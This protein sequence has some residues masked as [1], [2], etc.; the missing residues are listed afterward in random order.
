[1]LAVGTLAACGGAGSNDSVAVVG[2]ARIAKATLDQWAAVLR[3]GRAAP[4]LS[5]AQREQLNERAL[6]Y[7]ISAEW[8]I[9]EAEDRSALPSAVEVHQRLDE[10]DQSSFPG[11]EA[12]LREFLRISGQTVA[13]MELEVR[14]QLIASRLRQLAIAAAPAVTKAQ[15]AAYYNAHP[16]AFIVAEER[17]I[18]LADRKSAAAAEAMMRRVRAGASLAALGVTVTYERPSS[19]TAGGFPAELVRAIY[20]AAPHVLT[21]PVK[22]G[23]DY[24]V[25]EV[26]R[27][28]PPR[29]ETLQQASPAIAQQLHEASLRRALTAAVGAW[30]ARWTAQTNC[31]PGYVVQK[32]R[33][34]SGPRSAE[35]PLAF[36]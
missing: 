33:Q 13:D 19:L 28:R 6:A 16:H 36:G 34:Y 12:E 32:C 26:T 31:R 22:K 35:D 20:T 17:E 7:L 10:R 30:R 27:I 15:V 3:G 5:A 8:L 23:P 25:F 2:G 14:V 24:D 18:Q 11:G 29:R 9:G 21:G 4:A 1:M